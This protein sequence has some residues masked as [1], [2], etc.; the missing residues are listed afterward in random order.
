MTASTFFQRLVNWFIPQHMSQD[1]HTRKRVQMFIISHLFGPFIATPIPVVLWLADP[2]PMPHVLILA[3]SIYAFWP[4]LA[5]V[6]LF[7]RAYT[8]LAMASVVNLTFAIFWGT[9]NYGGASS[10]FLVW[11]V[12]VPLLAF[13]YLGAGWLPRVFV[14]GAILGGT[15]GL[16]ALYLVASFPEHIPVENMVVAGLLSALGA[17]IY[18]FMMAA[19]YSSVVDSQ[20][21]L[22]KEIDRHQETLKALTLAKDEAERANGAKSEFL[23]KMSHELRTPLNAVLGYSEILLE[24]AELDGRGEQIA[25]LQKISAAGKHLLSM[26]NDILDISKIEAGKMVLHLDTIDLNKLID[27]IEATARPMA[28][29]NTNSLTVTR[30]AELGNILTD[31]TKL[32][33]ATFN[34]LS[35][36]SKFTQNGQITLDVQRKS[37]ASGDWVEIAVRDTG[38]GISREQQSALFSNFSQANSKIAAVYGGTGLGLSLSQN[39]CQLMGGRIEFESQ[40]GQGSCFTIRIPAEGAIMLNDGLEGVVSPR[41]ERTPAAVVPDRPVA[42]RYERSDGYAGLSGH[43]ANH[44]SRERLLIIDDDR[45]FLELAERLFLRE[46]Y[47]PICTDAPQ[48]ALQIAR[49][50]KPSAIFLDILMPG[51]DGWDVLAALRADPLTADIPVF[52]ISILSERS[53]ALAAGAN[54][55]IMKPLDASKVKAALTA[56]KATRG[57]ARSKVAKG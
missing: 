57:L 4:F 50:V 54:G 41:P 29:K 32:R 56:L 1:L 11:L 51:F 30:G 35:N 44:D 36:A 34:L 46:D 7:P 47:A 14:L 45:N 18:V 5:L 13:M 33:Q 20:S 26:V 9:Y 37:E 27:E 55:I 39:L 49:T 25:D 19:Y 53:K 12:L 22:I 42:Q 23:A 28:A 38:I 3:A 21:E 43:A 6:K 10:P 48:S 15:A 31:A 8:P 17:N 52:M 24:D 16:Y 40:V 2:N